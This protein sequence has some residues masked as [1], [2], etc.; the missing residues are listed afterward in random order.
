MGTILTNSRLANEVVTQAVARLELDY[1]MGDAEQSHQS[2][3]ELL[4][5][6]LLG[7]F[8]A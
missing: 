6:D 2:L 8:W 1:D 4:K 7:M 3:D 5:A